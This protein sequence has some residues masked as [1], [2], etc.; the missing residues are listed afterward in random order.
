MPIRLRHSLL[1]IVAA[2]ACLLAVFAAVA[3]YGEP[4]VVSGGP[5][6]D[7]ESW[8]I[9]MNDNRLMV[10][11]DRNPDWASGD[12]H[13]TFSSDD[14]YTWSAPQAI[15]TG[16]GDQA[17]LSFVQLP[18]DTLML[19][20][21]SNES[22]I[23]KIYEAWSLDGVNWT[24]TGSIDLGWGNT[25]HYDPTVILEPDGSLTMSYVVSSFGVYIAHR[26]AGGSWDTDKTQVSSSG[27][28]PRVMKHTNGTYLYAYHR[29]TGGMYEYDV[30]TRTSTDRINWSPEVQITTNRNSHDPFP[31]QMPDGAYMV[32]YAKYQSPAYNLHRRLSYDGIYWEPE[33]QVTSDAVNNT[34]PHF[35]TEENALYLVWAHAVSY[36]DDHDV[37]FERFELAECHCDVSMIPDDDPIIVPRGGNF[38][39]TG[40]ITNPC[41]DFITTDVWYG[42]KAFGDFFE[43]GHFNNI[44]LNPGQFIQGH[45]YQHVPM[46][47]PVG[48]YE[49]IAFCGER[50]D[51]KNDSFSFEFTVTDE[52][53]TRGKMEWFSEG[54]FIGDGRQSEFADLTE[55]YPSPFNTTTRIRFELSEPSH[56]QLGIYNLI[57][58]KVCLLADGQYESGSHIVE[59]DASN[60]SSGIYFYRFSTKD[61]TVTKKLVLLK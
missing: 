25:M 48:E 16:P 11:F 9:R 30:F 33:E 49:Y 4:V 45:F 23:Y 13:V 28:R 40:V 41:E 51:A 36:P 35:F 29:R 54:E 3:A 31:N 22:G 27:Y 42:V 1:P 55:A 44:P 17:T 5:E 8:V 50:P 21:A 56:V 52:K 39:V 38:G 53:Y 6:N 34:Q 26:P 61:N 46:Y 2:T 15:I 18:G 10:V 58:Q 24:K 37:Y 57:G 59:W 14:G 12:L 60:Y 19:W 20:Y 43:Q 32:Y 7:Y 47:A